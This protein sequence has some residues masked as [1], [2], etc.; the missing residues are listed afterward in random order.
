MSITVTDPPASAPT[1]C[2]A[3]PLANALLGNCV[4]GAFG[5]FG[6]GYASMFMAD[7]SLGDKSN[8]PHA[9]LLAHN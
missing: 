8:L 6:N 9:Y 3:F 4:A 5:P 7:R 2:D 1:M